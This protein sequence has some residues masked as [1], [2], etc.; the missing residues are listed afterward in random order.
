MRT[1]ECSASSTN[2]KGPEATYVP[3][4]EGVNVGVSNGTLIVPQ[5]TREGTSGDGGG[6]GCREIKWVAASVSFLSLS[7]NTWHQ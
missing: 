6:G 4:K 7:Q 5:D 2:Q 3:R 1:H